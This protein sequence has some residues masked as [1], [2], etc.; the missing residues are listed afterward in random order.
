MG[1][2]KRLRFEPLEDRRLLSVFTV[3][4][5]QDGAVAKAGDLPGSLRQ[6]IFDANANP[7]AD[8][9]QFDSSLNGGTITLTA[10]ELAITDSLTIDGPGATNLTISGNNQSRIFDVNDGSNTTNINVEIDGLTLTGGN[11][12]GTSVDG[13]G[14]AIFSL[15]SLT[16][17]NSTITGNTAAISGGGIYSK[18]Y[19]SGATTIQNC[20][21]TNNTAGFGG[22]IWVSTETI[23]RRVDDPRQ[24]GLRK[25]R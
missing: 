7:G 20:T 21:I 23:W 18:D 15:E 3:T 5:L 22:G 17:K 11:A 19:A 4:N 12:P 6:A 2:E 1:Y 10:G 8:T 14:G 13:A 24:H 25:L 16:L 9:I